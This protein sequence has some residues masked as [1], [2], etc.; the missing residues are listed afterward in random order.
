MLLLDEFRLQTEAVEVN[1]S[2]MIESCRNVIERV[3]G[4]KRLTKKFVA[5]IIPILRKVS[6]KISR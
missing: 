2:E 6:T 1:Q 3:K 5:K 4:S